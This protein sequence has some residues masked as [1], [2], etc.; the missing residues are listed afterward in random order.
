MDAITLLKQDHRTVEKLFKQFEKAGDRAYVEKRATVDRIIEELSKH[1]AVEEQLFYP[2][3]RQTVP[4][5]E[6][7]ALE[8]LEEHHIV[9][10][11]LS[12]LVDMD[13]ED[14]RFDP[15]V[16]VLIE[17]VRHHVEEEEGGYFPM[18]RD[19][20][21]RKALGEL[22]DA[23][24]K[25]KAIAP[26][27]PHPRSPDTPPGNLIAGTKAGMVD[28]V[29]DVVSGVAQGSIA[30]LQDVVA[31]VSGAAKHAPS[32]TG[33]A[34]VKKVAAKTRDRAEKTTDRV[35]KTTAR[36]KREGEKALSGTA[37]TTKATARKTTKAATRKTA[38]AGH[39]GTATA[40]KVTASAKEATGTARKTG[41]RAA[42]KT[43]KATKRSTK[44]AKR[45]TSTARK[46]TAAR[47]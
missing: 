27:K 25:A 32:A 16:T 29:G 3:T 2:V 21:G 31:R 9:K 33:N 8:S 40:R 24:E 23:M 14:E 47:T 39:S 41:A 36:A 1:A 46:R 20:L 13:P 34:S 5:T 18:V 7:I 43:N 28:R 22:G 4:D 26:T 6:D 37:S 45:S 11:V 12:E 44:A 38:A 19:E 30:A 42:A 35:A 15:K 17:N 10:W